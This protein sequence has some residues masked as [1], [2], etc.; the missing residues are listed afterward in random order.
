MM[1]NPVV[2]VND[3]VITEPSDP[4]VIRKTFSKVVYDSQKFFIYG[5]G[6]FG[7]LDPSDKGERFHMMVPL[8]DALSGT[9]PGFISTSAWDE[10]IANASSAF[11]TAVNSVMPKI[12]IPSDIL[13]D[14]GIADTDDSHAA[15]NPYDITQELFNW[16]ITTVNG[17][18]VAE[19]DYFKH[20]RPSIGSPLFV[21]WVG[22]DDSD[23]DYS[24][25]LKLSDLSG[26]PYT[27][28]DSGGSVDETN[29]VG[30][31]AFCLL[32]NI[33][34]IRPG[35]ANPAVV[36][37]NPWD[38]TFTFGD[39]E[40][41]LTQTGAMAIKIGN[42]EDNTVKANLAEGASKEGPPQQQHF[43]DPYVIV[44]YPVWNGIVV[45]SGIQDSDRV[46]FTT[47]TYVPKIKGASVLNSPYSNG[48]DPAN[49][50][51]VLVGVDLGN[52]G[53]VTV[54]L[55]T[56]MNV[57]ARNVRFE[58][59]YLPCFFS[60]KCYFD[61]WFITSDDTSD[62]NCTHVV[63]PIW[64]KNNTS[65]V[66]N[67]DPPVVIESS[68]AGPLSG[69]HYSSIDWRLEQTL[70]TRYAGEIFGSVLEVQE[71]RDFPIKNANGLFGLS[72]VAGTT[73]DPSP[74]GDWVDYIKNVSVSLSLDGSNGSIT[75]DKFGIAGQD[76]TVVQSIGGITLNATGGE[77]TVAGNIFQGLAM[78]IGEGASADGAN[79]E[80]PLVGLEK[81]LDDIVLVNVPF[82]DGR[83]LSSTVDFLARYAGILHDLTDAPNAGTTILGVSEDVNVARFDWKA[84]TSIRT[85]LDE[86]M[87]NT[88]HNYLVKDGKIFFYELDALT[89]QPSTLGTDYKP[90]Y[91]NTKVISVDQNPDFEDMR[92]EIVAIG[93]R[94]VSAGQG[95]KIEDIPNFPTL[96]FAS[97][98]TVPDIP[99]A[100][101]LVR[102]LAGTVTEAEI[103]NMARN[104]ASISRKY[105]VIGRTSIPGNAGIKPYDRWGSYAIYSV[106][107]NL[108]FENKTW[109]TD[110]EFSDSG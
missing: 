9:K 60:S 98:T 93:L 85:A 69:T 10:T 46:V 97:N 26:P 105:G 94:A 101:S 73:G 22:K 51:E 17:G 14:N 107:H 66:L 37:Q 47:S 25:V 83:T 32:V 62:I 67:P 20:I 55:G 95:T 39:V 1:S 72:F 2:T 57:S 106:T 49:P 13:V 81:K 80:I 109:T 42:A 74:S 34:P 12:F 77:G 54:D 96:A 104:L 76:G 92:N 44:V 40:M 30:S 33:T 19:A 6:E 86:I 70:F 102:P 50:D 91:P 64:T 52:P 48:F 43:A 18:S 84:G 56:Q 27:D 5:I 36:A 99:W 68:T 35:S 89:G 90:S 41:K 61:E 53:D 71:T 87:D 24:V 23:A 82:F 38:I 7:S 110:L 65:A 75:V 21:A 31:G 28:L 108:D 100:R 8:T 4:Q 45:A 3:V 79:W 103:S 15:V 11:V 16:E 59:A 88:L 78:G 58:L 63:H 29:L